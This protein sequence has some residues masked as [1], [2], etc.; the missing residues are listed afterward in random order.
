MF[1]VNFIIIRTQ[2]QFTEMVNN[3]NDNANMKVWRLGS[4]DDGQ[5]LAVGNF[6]AV[7][8]MDMDSLIVKEAKQFDQKSLATSPHW[9]REVGA[10]SSINFHIMENDNG[11]VNMTLFRFNST[12]EV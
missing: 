10:N 9:R 7:Q 12:Y 2:E 11:G 3:G 6:P 8:E 1:L 4:E 5:Y